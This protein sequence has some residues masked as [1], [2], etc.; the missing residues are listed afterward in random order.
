MAEDTNRAE[1]SS[2]W[3]AENWWAARRL[4]Y[5]LGLIVAGPLA[6]LCY[7]AVVDWCIRIKAP[8]EFE[9]TI[10]TAAFQG[11]CYLFMI[12]MG[13]CVLLAGPSVGTNRPTKKYR[14]VSENRI[15]SRVLVLCPI[16]VRG[17]RACGLLMQGSCW[18]GTK[19][20][21]EELARSS[22]SA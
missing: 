3:A 19:T 2:P 12:A 4:R 13:K 6:F 9:I 20:N 18:S 1:D 21:V 16:A 15:P 10:F 7:A 17:P 8:G 11:G 5:N 14:D 22:P